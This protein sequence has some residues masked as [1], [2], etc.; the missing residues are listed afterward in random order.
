MKIKLNVRVNLTSAGCLFTVWPKSHE[1]L[2]GLEF[3]TGQGS[4]TGEAVEDLFSRLPEI[5][6]IDDEFSVKTS[7]LEHI[8]KRPFQ[9]V[10][11]DML[12]TF[13]LK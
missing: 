10:H 1:Y 12:R 13:V 2:P 5:F 7:S 4:S 8:L 11:S 3:F 9:I 6:T